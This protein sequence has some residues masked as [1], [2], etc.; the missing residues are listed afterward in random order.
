MSA[1]QSND[2]NYG[3][4]VPDAPSHAHVPQATRGGGPRTSEGKRISSQNA[5]KHG[6]LSQD[7]VAGGES[8]EDWNEF[9]DGVQNHYGPIGIFEQECARHIA[10]ELWYLRRVERQIKSVSQERSMFAMPPAPSSY[11]E[12]ADLEFRDPDGV[13]DV[14]MNLDSLPDDLDLSEVVFEDIEMTVMTTSA[15]QFNFEIPGWDP[16]S[17][18]TTVA[19]LRQFLQ[20]AAEKTG[21]QRNVVI[22][23]VVDRA[24]EFLSKA[25]ERLSRRRRKQARHVALANRV[26]LPDYDEYQKLLRYKRSHER[27][28]SK[29]IAILE[30]S[31]RARMNT[32]PP[33]IRLQ[34]QGE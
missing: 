28:L 18:R 16:D 25:P 24:N 3:G 8:I 1:A 15:E 2:R 29:W 4:H 6:L 34:V 19:S 9:L 23:R 14:L 10:L 32:L 11:V 31:Q 12:I 7:P 33:P 26:D 21:L 5:C 27:S 22:K 13:L 20:L 17:R 30:T